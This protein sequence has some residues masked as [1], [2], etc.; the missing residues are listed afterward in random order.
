MELFASHTGGRLH[1]NG[2]RGL[3]KVD[4]ALLALIRLVLDD[5]WSPQPAAAEL[6]RQVDD[7]LVLYRLRARVRNALFERPS[8]VAQRAAQT[9]A[10]LLDETGP[11]LVR[12][13]S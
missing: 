2:R 12:N 4:L 7:D 8:P 11:P 5:S 13:G 9:L 3:D 10:V 1:R 6:R